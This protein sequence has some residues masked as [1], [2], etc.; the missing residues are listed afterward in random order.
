MTRYYSWLCKIY[1]IRITDFAKALVW[2]KEETGPVSVF[3]L[4]LLPWRH[5]SEACFTFI[6]MLWTST[7]FSIFNTYFV[8]KMWNILW[9]YEQNKTFISKHV[10]WYG[11]CTDKGEKSWPLIELRQNCCLDPKEA[12]LY[13]YMLLWCN[14][15]TMFKL[16]KFS[17]KNLISLSFQTK[18]QIF[19]GIF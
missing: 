8:V 13:F 16:L 4:H 17:W 14:L 2:L 11:C 7:I 3:H 10:F 9:A 12:F 5:I 18:Y 15:E 1:P 19:N 6:V